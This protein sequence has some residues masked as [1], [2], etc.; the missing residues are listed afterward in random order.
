MG[1]VSHVGIYVGDGQM[2]NAPTTGARVRIDPV[3]TG[4]WGAHYHGAGRVM[5]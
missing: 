5:S 4:Y 1:W 2:I 3:F